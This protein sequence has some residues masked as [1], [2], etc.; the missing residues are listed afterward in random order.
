MAGTPI[1]VLLV[2]DN[3]TDIL[4]VRSILQHHPPDTFVLSST[5]RLASAIELAR[6]APCDVILLDLMMP[7]ESGLDICRRLRG[8][9]DA[10][11]AEAE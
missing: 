6:Q 4:L 1:H 2:E 10:E 11:D 5:P 9:G 8:Q 3:P 7:G